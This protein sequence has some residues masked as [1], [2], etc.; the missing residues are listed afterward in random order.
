MRTGIFGG[1]FD[2]PHKGHIKMAL[3]AKKELGLDRLILVPTGQAPHKPG[4][5]ASSYDRA[6]MCRVLCE[7]YGFELSL[8]EV[9]KQGNCYTADLL[10]YFTNLYPGDE[11]YLVVGGDSMDYMDK[12]YK[13]DR[14]FQLCRVVVAR[15]SGTAD[16]KA[17]LLREKFGAEIIFLNC[18]Y[19][20]VS[21]TGIREAVSGGKDFSAL[22]EKETAEYIL[23]NNLYR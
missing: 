14:I 6:Q 8:Y 16:E 4:I 1:S 7:K 12:W 18:E 3:A 23:K 9:E 10:E 20:D 11:F 15:R 5:R 13:P 2:P 22:I 21:S 17:E 19:T